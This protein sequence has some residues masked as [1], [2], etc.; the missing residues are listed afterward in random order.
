MFSSSS[1]I[2]HPFVRGHHAARRINRTGRARDITA[3]T[4][5]AVDAH[6]A[7]DFENP[8]SRKGFVLDAVAASDTRFGDF[9]HC[10]F[11]EI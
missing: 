2:G 3:S 7:D 4:S 11:R 5:R 10:Q 8:R 1:L 6:G 9:V